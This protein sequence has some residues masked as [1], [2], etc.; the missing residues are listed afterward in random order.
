MAANDDDQRLRIGPEGLSMPPGSRRGRVRLTLSP[1][2]ERKR[3]KELERTEQMLTEDVRMA[4]AL[5][6]MIEHERLPREG[7]LMSP[8]QI[9]YH[10]ADA[11]DRAYSHVAVGRVLIRVGVQGTSNGRVLPWMVY[12]AEDR[13]EALIDQDRI[14]LKQL[15]IE[16]G[17]S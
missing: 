11:Q 13:L 9:Q 6:E 4:G 3:R 12:E 5:L 14:T 15:K 1:A 7:N 8:K 10:F 16:L 2:E 17:K